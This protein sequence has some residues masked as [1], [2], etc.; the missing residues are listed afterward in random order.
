M[1]FQQ[2]HEQN[3]NDASE[4]AVICRKNSDVGGMCIHASFVPLFPFLTV[5]CTYAAPTHSI[6]LEMLA[7]TG[8]RCLC[9]YPSHMLLLLVP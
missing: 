8:K 3:E 9:H 7:G 1:L 2:K 5:D 4:E 6:L